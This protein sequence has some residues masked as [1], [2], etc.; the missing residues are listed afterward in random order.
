MMRPPQK[1]SAATNIAARGPA[2]STH[3]PATAADKPKKTIAML[4]IQPSAA[5][6]QSPGMVEMT[7]A[8]VFGSGQ[9]C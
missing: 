3:F 8:E 1:Q 6:D 5:I 9:A 4:N 7:P 2:R